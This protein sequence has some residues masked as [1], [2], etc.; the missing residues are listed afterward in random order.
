MISFQANEHK[1]YLA[2]RGHIS[3]DYVFS[4]LILTDI[5]KFRQRVLC[6][7]KKTLSFTRLD[8]VCVLKLH[9]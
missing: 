1:N 3:F 7:S 9:M 4:P 6:S 2:N 8:V 5:M